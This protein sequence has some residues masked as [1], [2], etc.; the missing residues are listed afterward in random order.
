MSF[1][2]PL[3]IVATLSEPPLSQRAFTQMDTD[4]EIPQVRFESAK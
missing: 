1:R 2:F 3:A 4:G